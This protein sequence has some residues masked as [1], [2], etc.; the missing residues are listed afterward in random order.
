MD[1]STIMDIYVGAIDAQLIR[2]TSFFVISKDVLSC[3]KC[4]RLLGSTVK[5][6]GVYGCWQD[7]LTACRLSST[8]R[9]DVMT[10]GKML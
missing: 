9:S 2:L 5:G 7:K 1:E 6:S 10:G 3:F 4:I 8:V